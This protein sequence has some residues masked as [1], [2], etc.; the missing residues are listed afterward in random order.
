M[1]PTV[2]FIF[3]AIAGAFIPEASSLRNISSSLSVQGRPAGR[4]PVICSSLT[5][6]QATS[7][8]A[9]CNRASKRL[10]GIERVCEA[11]DWLPALASYSSARSRRRRFVNLSAISA[12]LR[13]RAA[14]S[15]RN[16]LSIKNPDATNARRYASPIC[17]WTKATQEG[18]IRP[19]D[20]F[21][22]GSTQNGNGKGEHGAGL[23]PRA[24]THD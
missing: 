20:R 8:R 12:R 23:R 13:H 19:S 7:V 21:W 3:R 11:R 15:F 16:E 18:V 9:C 1:A 4:G 17:R 22:A 6:T 5:K 14:C 24:V 2:R 10:P